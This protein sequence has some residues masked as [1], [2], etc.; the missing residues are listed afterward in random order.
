MIISII[1]FYVLTAI[2]FSVVSWYLRSFEFSTSWNLFLWSS[3]FFFL[4]LGPNP[5]KLK[6][7]LKFSFIL[8]LIFVFT[9]WQILYKVTPEI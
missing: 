1:H 7:S 2:I 5:M 6:I 8:D 9:Q 3:F 4:L